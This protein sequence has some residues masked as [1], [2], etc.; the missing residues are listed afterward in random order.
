MNAKDCGIAVL[1]LILATSVWFA[2]GL[3]PKALPTDLEDW[4]NYFRAEVFL[5]NRIRPFGIRGGSMAPTF[6]D[7][8]IVF[9]VKYPRENLMVGDI[10][11]FYLEKADGMV[12]HRVISVQPDGVI[13]KGDANFS[14]DGELITEIEGL[15]IGVLFSSR[16]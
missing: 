14:D 6:R 2:Q 16:W 3:Q 12:A 11:V 13:T 9:T 4:T 1:A 5:D 10:A 8:D 7:D 15:A